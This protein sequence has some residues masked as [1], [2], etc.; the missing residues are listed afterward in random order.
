M[1]Y[2][3]IPLRPTKWK[4]EDCGIIIKKIT[5]R[6][7]NWASKHLSFAGKIQS[8]VHVASWDKVFFPKAYGDLGFKDGAKWNQVVNSHLFTKDN[9][10]RMHI[11]LELN[12]CPICEDCVE[13]H[14]HLF[15]SCCLSHKV[16]ELV[17]DWLGNCM[18]PSDYKGW[19]S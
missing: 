19:I 5:Q 10:A 15:F 9:M 4:A 14:E 3:G 13:T 2:L 18:W 16:V 1:K 17:F 6:L 11:P 7:H 12:K 8:K